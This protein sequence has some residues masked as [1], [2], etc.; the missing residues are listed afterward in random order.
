VRHPP[1]G[2]G[3]GRAREELNPQLRGIKGSDAIKAF[4]KAGGIAGVERETISTSRC[5]MVG[6]SRFG[7]RMR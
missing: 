3:I 1:E 7:V 4:E 5:Q 2:Q 6:L